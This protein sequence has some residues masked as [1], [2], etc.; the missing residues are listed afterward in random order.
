MQRFLA[1]LC[2]ILCSHLAFADIGEPLE[3]L[4]IQDGGRIKPFD[5]FARAHGAMILSVPTGQ[6]IIIR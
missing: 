3:T 5:T 4:P 6:G 1:S 2:L